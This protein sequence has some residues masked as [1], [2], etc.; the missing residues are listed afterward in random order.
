MTGHRIRCFRNFVPDPVRFWIMIV[1]SLI[2]LLSGAAHMAS[3]SYQV[4]GLSLLQEDTI[5]IGYMAFIGMNVSFPML[6]RLRFR[7]TTRSILLVSTVVIICCHVAILETANVWILCIINFIAGFFRML[8]VF[9]AMVCIQLILTPTR[10]YA[11]FYSS[12]HR[13]LLISFTLIPCTIC[14]ILS[15]YCCFLLSWW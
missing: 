6:F 5:M 3:M 4:N 13:L 9:E 11:V 15:S 12:F 10:N 2:Y 14:I 7:F 1:I 8:A